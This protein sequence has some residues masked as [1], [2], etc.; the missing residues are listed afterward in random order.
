VFLKKD[1]TELEDAP[2]GFELLVYKINEAANPYFP[3]DWEER[4]TLHN[5]QLTILRTAQCPYIDIAIDNVIE[6]ASKLQIKAEILHLQTRE[7]L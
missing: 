6:A 1:F 5:N 3:N 4:L 7:E 2:Y